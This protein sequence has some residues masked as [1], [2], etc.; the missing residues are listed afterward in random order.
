MLS[1]SSATPILQ[2]ASLLAQLACKQARYNACILTRNPLDIGVI[3]AHDSAYSPLDMQLR[4]AP[5]ASILN[6]LPTISSWRYIL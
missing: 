5:A 2:G 1:H 6:V 3:S 4:R